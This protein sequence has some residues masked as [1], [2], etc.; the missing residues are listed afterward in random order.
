MNKR[1]SLLMI[2]VLLSPLAA[3]CGPADTQESQDLEEFIA[4]GVA[5]TLTQEALEQALGQSQEDQE[6]E[7]PTAVPPTQT[8][9]P[10]IVH[11]ML[12]DAPFEKIN[13]YLTDFNSIDFAFEGYTYGD[14]FI[15]NRFERP[16]TAEMVEYRGYLDIIRSN[17]RVTPPWIYVDILLAENLPEDSQARYG[18]ELDLDEDGRG[19][20]IVL[21]GQPVSS[22]WVVEGVAVY[23]DTDGD[24]GGA[25]PL[26][27]D[28]VDESL[29]GYEQV[30]FEEGRGEDPDLAWVRLHP[31]EEN[32]LQMAVKTDLT[33][34]A[35][36]LWSVWADEGL[37]DPAMFDYNDR[38]TFSMA[39][40][41]YPD[42]QFHP[43]KEI[44]LVDSTCRSWYGYEPVG[45]E[46]GLCQVYIKEG[47]DKGWKLCYQVSDTFFV[48]SDIC[49]KRCPADLPDRY[50]CEPCTI[51]K[52]ED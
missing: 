47:P 23:Q 30:I 43:I 3:S 35:G 32:I 48:C 10:E 27:S 42:H 18:L 16:F 15:F 46:P 4:A 12:P 20:V 45:D 40:S 37:N 29:T 44:Y 51:P 11:T 28:P 52:T 39:G 31:E 41:P 9:E 5:S 1:Y 36:F 2:M 34:S 33:G 14:Q 49:Q 8:P 19:D 22:E 26:L 13:T 38:F 21:A 24:V 50:F 25:Q 6:T 7:E 17:M